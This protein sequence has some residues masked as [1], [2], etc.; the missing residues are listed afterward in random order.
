L[1]PALG[2]AEIKFEEVSSQANISHAG[3]TFGASWGDFNGDGWPDIWVGNHNSKP[4]LYLNKQNGTFEDIIDRVWSGDPNADTHGA[5]WADFDNDGDQDLI[6]LVD[7]QEN[8]DGTFCVG[9]G[10]NL[11]FVNDSGKLIERAEQYG[12][13]HKGYARSPVWCDMNRDGLLDLL[14]VNTRSKNQPTSKVYLQKKDKGF[15][16]SN[17]AL[18]FRDGPFQKKEKLWWR[19][20]KL[21]KFQHPKLSHFAAQNHLE[22]AM[23][24]D[25]SSDGYPD[26][27]LFARPT[28]IFSINE[29]PFKEITNKIRLPQL[30]GIS[31]VAAADFNGDQTID[32][33][34][35]R[36]AYMPSDVIQ[37][38]PS[39]VKGRINGVG[40]GKPKAVSF[41]TQGDV[42]FQIYP[43]WL[44][45]TNVY[46]GSKGRHPT[47]RY[48]LLSSQDPDVQMSVPPAGEQKKGVHISYDTASNAWTIHNFTKGHH[49][50]FIAIANQP[51]REIKTIG[52]E[53]FKEIGVD[54]LLMNRKRKF[55]DQPLN[56]EVGVHTSGYFVAA[57]DFDND[58][59]IDLYLTCTGPVQNL[60]N[61]LFENDG[62]GNFSLVAN[63][64]GAAGSQLGRG[65]VV[66]LA[67]YNRDGFVDLFITNGHDPTSPFTSDGPHQLFKNQGNGNHWLEIDL[68]GTISNR[69]GIGARV[70]VETKGVVQI[71]EQTGGMHRITQNH[72][73]IHFGLSQHGVVDRITVQWPNGNEQHLKNVTAD[74][75][76]TIV[77]ST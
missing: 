7:V 20:E 16:E 10:K 23:L 46:I 59:D 32:I 1:F 69:D 60:P 51:I 28:R 41:Q 65:D 54:A 3:T 37:T 25:L 66:A 76:L 77:E 24:S 61:R 55:V 49:V 33:Y 21:I 27:L 74:Q 36:G 39:R 34:V 5:A 17:R 58:M 72:Q 44:H 35:A 6:E 22:F 45:L 71:R 31:D 13:A 15:I 30:S 52:F 64:G 53:S 8:E 18:K 43:T 14:V 63:A 57:A 73:R 26:L 50:D 68:V 11:F 48:F 29:T 19:I 70:E 40:M 67:D 47:G 42:H 38:A 75:I 4:T 62:K 56:R 2:L 12:L 9:C